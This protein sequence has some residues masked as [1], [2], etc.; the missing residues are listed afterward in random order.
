M[1]ADVKSRNQSL[2]TCFISAPFGVDLGALTNVLDKAQIHWEWAKSESAYSDRLPGNLRKIIRDV[3][4]L[5]AVLFGNSAD[6]NTI[7]EIGIAVGAGKPV[8]LIVVND[9]QIP[10]D[11]AGLL[12]VR[13]SLHDENTIQL[14]L[15]LMMRSVAQG[16]RYNVSASQKSRRAKSSSGTDVAHIEA[17]GP[18]VASAFESEVLA[19]IE[20]AGGTVVRQPR[21]HVEVTKFIPD[22]LVWLPTTDPELLNPAVIE[23]RTFL[24]LGKA[25]GELEQR[26]LAFLQQTGVRTGLII[27]RDLQRQA[28]AEVQGG[29]LLN[30]F[31]LEFEKFR[32]LL[33]TG[34]LVNYLRQERN[35]AAHGLR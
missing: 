17:K 9:T 29:P 21:T 16:Y 35:R 31:T 26:M 32:H 15:D 7:F 19:L 10:F 33:T 30:I 14:H 13:S 12:Q 24:S 28:I 6:A 20:R 27:V 34:E 3:D 2:K 8:L 1:S 23:V 18:V 22:A 25:P 4:F 11:L 5:V